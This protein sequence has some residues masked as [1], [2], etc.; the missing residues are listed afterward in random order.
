[1]RE[2]SFKPW[3]ELF[4]HENRDDVSSL[5]A[6]I[7]DALALGEHT[8]FQLRPTDRV[9]DIYNERYRNS[10][11]ADMLEIESLD[12]LLRRGHGIKLSDETWTTVEIGDLVAMVLN[13]P[14][15]ARQ[16]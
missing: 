8:R 12:D 5:L 15:R 14:R 10:L 13:G 3:D 6:D 4:G 16:P 2:A 11:S 7:C 9:V 1:M